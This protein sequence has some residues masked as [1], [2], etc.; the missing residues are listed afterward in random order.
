MLRVLSSVLLATA[1]L[2]AQLRAVPRAEERQF[3]F[4]IGDW[5]VQNRSD[6][7]GATWAMRLEG[8]LAPLR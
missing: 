5:S 3:D 6:D 4:W 8:E 1:P 7:G 2:A